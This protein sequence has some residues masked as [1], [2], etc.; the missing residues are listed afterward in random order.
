MKEGQPVP[1]LYLCLLLNRGSLT[2]CPHR[3]PFLLSQYLFLKGGSVPSSWVTSTVFMLR[4][5]SSFSLGFLNDEPW[6]NK[7]REIA[8]KIFEN[9]EDPYRLAH[10]SYSADW[11]KGYTKSVAAKLRRFALTA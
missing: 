6:I 3:S 7:P 9:I 4:F 8:N 5:Y 1:D 10:P 2:R 11:G